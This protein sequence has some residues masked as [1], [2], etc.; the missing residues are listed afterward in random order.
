VN[1]AAL[2]ERALRIRWFVR[3]PI[4]MFRYGFGWLLAGR[5]LMLEHTGRASGLPR[6]A[7]LEVIDRPAPGSFRVVSG[8]GPRSQWLR[9]VLAEP[10]V[11]IWVGARR[12]VP[13]AAR[14]RTAAETAEIFADYARDHPGTWRNLRGLLDRQSTAGDYSDVPVVDF[15]FA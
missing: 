8:L 6:Y 15:L 2:F 9:N 3:L 5:F 10:Q 11:R 14:V 12:A 1:S 7:V 13:A 4:P